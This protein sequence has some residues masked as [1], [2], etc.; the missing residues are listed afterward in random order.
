MTACGVMQRLL[1]RVVDR[2]E[3]R[4]TDERGGIG[5]PGTAALRAPHCPERPRGLHTLQ[6]EPRR[7]FFFSFSKS[8]SLAMAPAARRWNGAERR[9]S[10]SFAW[11]P[12]D[13]E[14]VLFKKFG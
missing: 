12:G 11:M 8:C 1:K 3:T 4:C 2:V 14:R 10:H 9:G 5:L 7:F 6:E 13:F